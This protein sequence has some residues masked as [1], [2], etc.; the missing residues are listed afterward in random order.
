MIWNVKFVVNIS[1]VII[2]TAY[3][4]AYKASQ[5]RKHIR[6]RTYRDIDKSVHPQK[7]GTYCLPLFWSGPS[8]YLRVNTL[9]EEVQN[10]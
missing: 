6:T 8:G 2:V 3:F 10:N 9:S 5:N 4:I 7:V 1:I